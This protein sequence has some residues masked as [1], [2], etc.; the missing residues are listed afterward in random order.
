M[1]FLEA[2]EYPGLIKQGERVS[3]IAVPTALVA[4][5]WPAKT[6]RFSG[7]PAL[8]TSSLQAAGTGLRPEMEFELAATVPGQATIFATPPLLSASQAARIL[9]TVGSGL[10]RRLTV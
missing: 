2:A 8:S 10:E 5:N 3:T 1:V 9:L 6:N 7:S 4:F